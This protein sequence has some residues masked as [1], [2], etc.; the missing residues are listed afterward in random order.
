MKVS[1][2]DKI[3][4]RVEF[5]ETK[6]RSFKTCG[7][8]REFTLIHELSTHSDSLPLLSLSRSARW[9]RERRKHV[10]N[11]RRTFIHRGTTSRSI[12]MHIYVYTYKYTLLHQASAIVLIMYKCCLQVYNNYW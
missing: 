5:L 7:V 1:Y 4:K 8:A 3:R 10:K 9:K 12:Q 11:I 2:W 6:T